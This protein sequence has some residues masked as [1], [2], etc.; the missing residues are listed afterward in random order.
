MLRPDPNLERAK[1]RGAAA[2]AEGK[3]LDPE[4]NLPPANPYAVGSHQWHDW[5]EGWRDQRDKPIG[6]R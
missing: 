3:P 2:Q 4:S 6:L 5:R 1:Q